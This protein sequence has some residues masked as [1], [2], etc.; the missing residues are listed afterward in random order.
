M[1]KYVL[2]QF[3]EDAIQDNGWENQLIL[4]LF[5]LV[6][7]DVEKGSNGRIRAPVCTV[8]RLPLY[9]DSVVYG[10]TDRHSIGIWI[11]YFLL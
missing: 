9:L 1:P 10:S 4:T 8:L 6:G 7:M 2:E 11:P 5:L 3:L